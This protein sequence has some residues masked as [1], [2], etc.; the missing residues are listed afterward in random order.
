MPGAAALFT[1]KAPGRSEQV[2]IPCIYFFRHSCPRPP[3]PDAITANYPRKLSG[4]QRLALGAALGL[5]DKL[6]TALVQGSPVSPWREGAAA[7]PCSQWGWGELLITT[8]SPCPEVPRPAHHIDRGSGMGHRP[9]FPAG[10][11]GNEPG[12]A[13]AAC[14]TRGAGK[15]EGIWGR[16]RATPKMPGA[17]SQPSRDTRALVLGLLPSLRLDHLGRAATSRPLAVG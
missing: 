9:T 15:Q 14:P 11:L 3:S 7:S 13:E 12:A 8:R 4:I 17:T 6:G 5:E 1:N 2:I 10:S 16:G